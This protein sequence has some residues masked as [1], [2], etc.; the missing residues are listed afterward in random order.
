MSAHRKDL[1]SPTPIDVSSWER[2]E[3]FP[4]HPVGSKPKRVL[5]CPVDNA[6]PRL[7]A[8]HSYL[9]KIAQGWRAQQLWSE[10]IAYRIASVVQLEVPPCFV[11]VDTETGEV[12]ALVEFF[13]GHPQDPEPARLVHAADLLQRLRIGP[14][15][16]RPHTIRLNLALCRALRID[17]AT[18]W[19]ARALTF[20][21]MIGNSDRHPENWG[22]LNRIHRGRSPAWSLAPV[23]DNGTSMGYEHTEATLRARRGPIWLAQYINK[24]RHHCG[25]DA[26]SDLP[27]PHM[28]LCRRFLAAYP[29]TRPAM[30]S[31]TAFDTRLVA[32]LA[33]E[34]VGVDVSI[35]FTHDRAQFVSTLVETRR[36]QLLTIIGE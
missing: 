22:F 3:A 12:G 16:D 35:P 2:D 30:Q 24:G 23:F 4:I 33:A 31:V 29:E 19:W 10:I 28:D 1:E 8:G 18:A 9:F 17:G 5:R 26:G 13:Y 6:D 27:T 14:R 32:Q 7:I 21:A 20:D 25:W 34:Y 36:Q 15:T 11:A